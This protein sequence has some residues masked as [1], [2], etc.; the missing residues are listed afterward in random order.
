MPQDNRGV[1]RLRKFYNLAI[2]GSWTNV[3][4]ASTITPTEVAKPPGNYVYTIVPPIVLQKI[5][6]S[7]DLE[8][9]VYT[10]NVPIFKGLWTDY[11]D[12]D[13]Y[14]GDGMGIRRYAMT[15]SDLNYGYMHGFKGS[16]STWSTRVDK[17]DYS[18]ETIT[19]AGNLISVCLGGIPLGNKSYGWFLAGVRAPYGN[20]RSSQSYLLT[21]TR[22]EIERLNYSNGT[23]SLSGQYYSPVG[24]GSA[25]HG[26]CNNN[27]GWIATYYGGIS[28]SDFSNDLISFTSRAPAADTQGFGIYTNGNSNYAWITGG[29]AGPASYQLPSTPIRS[30]VFRFD[31]ANDTSAVVARGPLQAPKGRHSFSGNQSVGYT[32]Y[33][34][35]ERVHK[36][37]YSNDTSFGSPIVRT[38]QNVNTTID[39]DYL[40]AYNTIPAQSIGYL[41][42]FTPGASYWTPSSAKWSN[43]PVHIT[44]LYTSSFSNNQWGITPSATPPSIIPRTTTPSSYY[45]NMGYSVSHIHRFEYATDACWSSYR[46][47]WARSPS[48][49]ETLAGT[50]NSN[51]GWFTAGAGGSAPIFPAGPTERLD[52]GNDTSTITRNPASIIDARYEFVATGN[53][54]YGWWVGGL[55]R[56]PGFTPT[57][58]SLTFRLDYANDTSNKTQRGYLVVAT[59]SH[60]IC[61]NAS[62]YAWVFGQ[63]K[64]NTSTNPVPSTNFTSGVQRIDFQNDTANALSRGNM[65]TLFF[66][67]YTGSMP[68]PE[69]RV[70]RA[71]NQGNY[72]Y[73]TAWVHAYSSVPVQNL[74]NV[75]SSYGRIDYSNDT[76]TALS[77][78]YR[79][80][81]TADYNRYRRSSYFDMT[82]NANAAYFGEGQGAAAF[83]IPGY[84]YNESWNLYKIDYANDTTAY[85]QNVLWMN[86][87]SYNKS[88]YPPLVSESESVGSGYGFGGYCAITGAISGN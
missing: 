70:V 1:W 14:H 46:G 40:R 21:N 3:S 48:W 27:Y 45:Y 47:I 81:L 16:L 56:L 43:P 13:I 15:T 10:A 28:R 85:A 66:G 38:S 68:D 75:N 8:E 23:S 65:H 77:R 72:G 60:G 17:V 22:P 63:E 11:E 26:S 18:N 67:S 41:Y 59:T 74:P 82:G 86:Y 5:D 57:T 83:S 36:I 4:Y 53:S 9:T 2:D 50:G 42:G 78:G 44:Y 34:N 30:S 62:S 31:Y 25:H 73:Y 76:V 20:D 51:Y 61:S 24:P 7:N 33:G 71:V 88:D 55:F 79:Y 19:S 54:N 12:L 6:T 49:S 64:T 69:N 35:D 58:Q 80:G 39:T 29:A 32:L 84:S 37:D 52:Y 87:G